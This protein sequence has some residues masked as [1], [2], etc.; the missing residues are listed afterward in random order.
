MTFSNEELRELLR[1]DRPSTAW[2]KAFELYNTT[3]EYNRV[4]MGCRSCFGKVRAWLFMEWL[5]SL[6]SKL[7]GELP[8]VEYVSHKSESDSQVGL[9]DDDMY[10]YLTKKSSANIAE[11]FRQVAAIGRAMGLIESSEQKEYAHEISDGYGNKSHFTQSKHQ[12]WVMYRANLWGKACVLLD[13]IKE[14]SKQTSSSN[15]PEQ[16]QN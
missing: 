2:R 6:K 15:S 14:S 12:E 10:D 13:M 4:G 16:Q 7:Y 1:L 8:N 3:H 5:P 11:A 9:V